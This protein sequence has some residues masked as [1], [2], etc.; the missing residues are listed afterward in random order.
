MLELITVVLLVRAEGQGH[1][2]ME[3]VRISVGV[4]YGCLQDFWGRILGKCQ[5]YLAVYSQR[6]LVQIALNRSAACVGGRRLF[7]P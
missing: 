3:I 6:S 1:S 2:Q 5:R 4:E 7:G